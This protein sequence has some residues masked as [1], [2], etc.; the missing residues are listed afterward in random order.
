MEEV[1]FLALKYNNTTDKKIPAIDNDKSNSSCFA[2][3]LLFS[4]LVQCFEQ[5]SLAGYY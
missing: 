5:I 3:K 2:T 1:Y 4:M